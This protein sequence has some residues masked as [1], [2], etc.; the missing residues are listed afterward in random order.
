M[1]TNSIRVAA[2][3]LALALTACGDKPAKTAELSQAMPNL[4]LPPQASFV[5]RDAGADA[6]KIVLR[7]PAAPDAVAAY[8][9]NVFK[10]GS[11]RL[12]HEDKAPTGA[13]SLLA[14]QDGPPLWVRITAGEAGGSLVELSGAV[15]AKADSAAVK[16]AS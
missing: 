1:P 3:G 14:D 12:I 6:M 9:R 5:S 10:R 2:L 8:Y 16:P 11:W 7:S 15:V 4:P 13:T